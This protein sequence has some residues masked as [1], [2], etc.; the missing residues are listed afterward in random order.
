MFDKQE[1]AANLRSARA[2]LDMTQAEFARRAGI[3]AATVV[4]Y[5]SGRGFVPGA[6]KIAAMCR[7]LCISPN[8]LLG[9]K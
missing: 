9:W 1:F 5:E 6:D 2:R 4:E 7:A 3:S 8:D